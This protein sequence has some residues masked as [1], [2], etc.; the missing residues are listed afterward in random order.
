MNRTQKSGAI[1]RLTGRLK[2]APTIYVTDFTG[3]KVKNMT[4][5]RRRFRTA[6]AEYVVVKN[7]LAQRALREAQVPGFEEALRGPTAFVFAERDP[8]AAAK[9]LA[10][11]EKQFQRPKVKAGRVDGRPVTAADVARLAMLPGREQLLA[12][13]A[14]A[15]Q[16]PLAAFAGALHGLLY[17]LVGALEALREQR[18]GAA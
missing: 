7:T 6:G 15:M 1:E 2:R 14:G 3:L 8:A 17:Q 5:L 11:F 4:E 10:E 13:M 16:A 9:I 12:Q 18:A